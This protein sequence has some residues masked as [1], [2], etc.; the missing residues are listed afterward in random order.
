MKKFKASSDLGT[1]VVKSFQTMVYFVLPLYMNFYLIFTC[2]QKQPWRFIAQLTAH[3]LL[4]CTDVQRT[5]SFSRNVATWQGHDLPWLS[6]EQD[7]TLMH[8]GD[9]ESGSVC[10]LPRLDL[11]QLTDCPGNTDLP[12]SWLF[13][14]CKSTR[15]WKFSFRDR[16]SCL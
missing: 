9:T 7:T 2:D 13:L 8:V 16:D 3:H 10:A 11:F 5:I 4:I 12:Q 14:C 6:F 15:S 1:R